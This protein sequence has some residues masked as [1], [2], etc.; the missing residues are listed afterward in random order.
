MKVSGQVHVTAVSP[1]GKDLGINWMGSWAD[2]RTRLDTM[3]K[4]NISI[5]AKNQTLVIQSVASHCTTVLSQFMN[6]IAKNVGT[7]FLFSKNTV[8]EISTRIH[9]HIHSTALYSTR[10]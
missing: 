8:N 1:I 3:T 10:N 2:S 9:N 6:V 4:Q 7:Q 5:S